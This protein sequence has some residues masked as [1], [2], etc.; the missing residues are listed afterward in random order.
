M[1]EIKLK[2]CWGPISGY[3]QPEGAAY[4]VSPLVFG[5]DAGW[6]LH[7]TSIS[8]RLEEVNT[9]F[10]STYNSGKDPWGQLMGCKAHRAE[11][12]PVPAPVGM[13]QCVAMFSPLD[14]KAA[15][16]DCLFKNGFWT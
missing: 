1:L 11:L 9:Q 8:I 6:E 15:Q 3:G 10:S 16:M 4:G 14:S 2:D 13:L 7:H 5:D 12:C